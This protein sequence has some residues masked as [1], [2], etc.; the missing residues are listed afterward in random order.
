MREASETL[1]YCLILKC[2][3]AREDVT[4]LTRNLVCFHFVKN[5]SFLE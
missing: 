3:V 2:L 5:G 1:D 4:A